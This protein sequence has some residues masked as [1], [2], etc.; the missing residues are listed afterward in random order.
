MTKVKILEPTL[1]QKSLIKIQKSLIKNQKSLIKNQKG[2]IK[3]L[4]KTILFWLVLFIV[5]YSL[6]QNQNIEGRTKIEGE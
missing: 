4:L 5:I 3:V 2:L 1:I 6:I